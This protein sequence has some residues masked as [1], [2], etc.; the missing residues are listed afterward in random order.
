M[1]S[2]L[3]VFLLTPF[4]LFFSN[5]QKANNLN[6]KKPSKQLPSKINIVTNSKLFHADLYLLNPDSSVKAA[7]GA[8][9]Q[10]DS[11]F[12]AGVDYLD[13][14]K[15]T[16]INENFA[17]LRDGYLL[18][19]ERR[20]II[21]IRDTLFFN[22][23]KTTKR[24]YQF[25]FTTTSL[26]QP[27]LFCFLKD[28]YTGDSILVDLDGSTIYNFSISDAAS[29][30]PNRFMV[31][32]EPLAEGGIVPVTYSSIKA[33]QQNGNIDLEWKV[34][35]ELNIKNYTIERSSDGRTFNSIA[36][37]KSNV[38][39]SSDIYDW[40]D[41]NAISGQSF[42]R[43][44]STGINGSVQYSKV[45]KINITTN[46]SLMTLY[47]NPVKDGIINLQLTNMPKGIYQLRMLNSSGQS[48]VTKLINH[49][50]GSSFQTI[51]F[52]KNISKG[53]YELQII[54]PGN[55]SVSYKIQ[56]Q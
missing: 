40:T 7:D 56:Y 15:F 19:I 11:S 34:E 24:S 37:I 5:Q 10:Y 2:Q 42:Y 9:A 51:S 38:N 35:N 23:T 17:L 27:G 31:V 14:L 13:A 12:S 55:N 25:Q 26:T 16:N 8:V 49:S 1:R 50:G 22:L 41:A 6:N 32:F 20:P 46:N 45:V 28:G 54:Q 53:F 39:T 48:V 36:T 29:Q 47:P 18:S 4:L 3:F 33:W 21:H 44:H 30:D 43:V 52:N